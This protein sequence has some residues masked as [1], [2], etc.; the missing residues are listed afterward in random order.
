MG[1]STPSRLREGRETWACKASPSRSGVGLG[2]AQNEV[3]PTPCPSRK[4]E[5]RLSFGLASLALAALAARA[6][7]WRPEEFWRATPAELAASLADPAGAPAIPTRAEIERM[8]ERE[9]D[10]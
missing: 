4:R 9:T 7:G 8:L 1:G 6:L 5:G 10:G 2:E 3:G